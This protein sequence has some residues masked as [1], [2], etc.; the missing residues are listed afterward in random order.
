[1]GEWNQVEITCK[2]PLL[3]VVTNGTETLNVDLGDLK[4]LLGHHRQYKPV[5]D[6]P[7]KGFI[8][9]QGDRG[10]HVEFRDILI[11]EL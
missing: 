5:C 11:K 7:R 9:L 4:V 6:R 2:G 3:R 10:V 1:G 8:G